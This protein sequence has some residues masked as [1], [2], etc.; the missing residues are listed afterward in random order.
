MTRINGGT[1]VKGGFYW[2]PA[3]WQIVTV[4]GESG[5]LPGVAGDRF[6]RIPALALLLLAPVMGGLFVMFLPLIGFAMVLQHLLRQGARA[7]RRAALSVAATLAPS[8]R[9]GEAFFAGKGGAARKPSPEPP[10]E[11]GPDA[12]L[13]ALEKEIDARRSTDR[14]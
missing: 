3:E 12:R 5:V 7:A 13:D 2:R 14:S 8:W 4:S 9:P 1:K 6:V 10:I 11:P